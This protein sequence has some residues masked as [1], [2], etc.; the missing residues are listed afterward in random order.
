MSVTGDSGRQ[1]LSGVV[2]PGIAAAALVVYAHRH[3]VVHLLYAAADEAD[4]VQR[5]AGLLQLDEA[6]VV[7]V[8][9]QPMGW[10]LPGFRRELEAL[11]AHPAAQAAAPSGPPQPGAHERA[12]RPAGVLTVNPEAAAEPPLSAL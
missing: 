10:M 12:D 4:A 9:D 7:G 8:L 2:D 5:V 1:G 3:E 6:A 11:A